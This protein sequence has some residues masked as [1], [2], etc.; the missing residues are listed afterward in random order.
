MKYEPV[1]EELIGLIKKHNWKEKFEKALAN[2]VEWNVP[3]VNHVNTLEKYYKWLNDN[4]LD[5]PSE[6]VQGKKMYDRLCEF[7]FFIDQ[8]PVN[9][10]QNKVRPAENAPPDTPL[11]KWMV[12]YAN[13]W[14]KICDQPSSLTP[15][16]LQTFY[17]SPH[18]NMSEYMPD[19]GGW[20]TFN[21]FFA[22]HTKPGMRPVAAVADDRVIVSPADSTF[23]GWWQINQDS[24]ITVKGVEW[25]I[26]ELLESSPYR[27]S[28]RGGIFTHSFL[29]TTDYHRLHVPVGGTVLESR[30][31]QGQVYLD[32]EAV[33][34]DGSNGEH[35]L[36]AIREF[37]AQDAT[38][39]QFAQAR[40]LIVL[41]SPIG[42]VAVLPIGMCQVSSVVMTAEVGVK[43]RKGEEFAYFQFGGSDYVVL[44]QR[45]SNV[46]L[47]AQINVHYNQ[48]ECIGHAYPV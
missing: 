33:P 3:S 43:L 5:L 26:D 18:Y 34:V 39:Y 8:D 10:L 46:N 2:A 28:F 42:L 35:K 41:D 31:I 15:E 48:G 44:Y 17:D 23:V 38:G 14:G 27:D 16:S 24:K 20:K 36:D 21:Q 29:N 47:T 7:Y 22:R 32:V 45:A 25:S 19:P 4:L 6:N 12:N 40:G 1:V 13:A 11:E 9:E 37:D 30:P